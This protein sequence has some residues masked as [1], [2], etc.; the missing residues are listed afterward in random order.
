MKGMLA[1]EPAVLFGLHP[2]GMKLLVLGQI[3]VTLLA[4]CTCHSDLYTHN[5][6]LLGL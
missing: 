1:A 3:V 2:V 6:H 5:F 4:L